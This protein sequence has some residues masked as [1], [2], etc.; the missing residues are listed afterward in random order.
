MSATKRPGL[1]KARFV[2][3]GFEVEGVPYYPFRVCFTLA[4]GRRRS[5][6]RWSPGYTWIYDSVAREL[7]DTFGFGGVKERSCTISQLES[8]AA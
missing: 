2:R 3:R 6:V 1:A 8:E 7:H 4:D 5:W